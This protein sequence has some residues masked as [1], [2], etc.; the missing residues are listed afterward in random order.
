MLLVAG[1]TNDI[2][3]ISDDGDDTDGNTENDLQLR[4]LQRPLHRLRLLTKT[5]NIADTNG[6][7]S[8]G[9]GDTIT[10]SLVATNTGND[11]LSSVS[12][13]DVLSDLAVSLA[14]TTLPT[15]ISA[16]LG[17]LEGALQVGE[18]ATYRATFVV[19]S[20]AMNAGGVSNTAT[21]TAQGTNGG[22][23]TDTSDDPSTIAPNDATVTIL[24]T[25]PPTSSIT[26]TKTPI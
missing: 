24:S 12:I 9:I 6:D 7:G 16:S 2:F 19:N 18:Q 20:Q 25:T 21:V 23:I 5:A 3:D 11:A 4:G 26:L 15:F 1:K 14:L 10:Y 13:T 22:T 8:I 17:S